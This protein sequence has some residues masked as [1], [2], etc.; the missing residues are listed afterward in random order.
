[1]EVVRHKKPDRADTVNNLYVAGRRSTVDGRRWE[2][3]ARKISDFTL[4][5]GG[6]A[7]AR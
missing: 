5:D 6:I 2:M 1:M 7:I 3:A 4:G